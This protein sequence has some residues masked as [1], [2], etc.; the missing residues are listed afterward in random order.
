MSFPSSYGPCEDMPDAI[1]G[2]GNAPYGMNELRGLSWNSSG[3]GG[4]PP[5]P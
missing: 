3:G 5:Q 4:G 2:H 1:A